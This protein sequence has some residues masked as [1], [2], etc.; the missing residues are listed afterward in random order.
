MLA[1]I[2]GEWARCLDLYAGS[3]ALGIE[4]LSRDAQWVDYVDQ[5]PRCCA[6]IKQNLEKVGLSH[7]AHVYCCSVS[8]ALTFLEGKYD[9]IFI[10]PPYADSKLENLLQQVDSQTL[11]NKGSLV[12]IPHSS[13]ITLA[14]KYGELHLIKRK[15]HGDTCISIFYREVDE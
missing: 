6:I 15:Q 2:T 12:V 9:I 5:E 14:E 7:K 8:K 13:R 3:G 11:L 1:S 10:D 4:A